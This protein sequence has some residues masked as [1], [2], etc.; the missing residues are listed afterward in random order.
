MSPSAFFESVA[1]SLRFT[2]SLALSDLPER[3]YKSDN[4]LSNHP[5]GQSLCVIERVVRC[6]LQLEISPLAE[7]YS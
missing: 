6:P 2:H 3:R 4:N 5:D 7:N 1:D